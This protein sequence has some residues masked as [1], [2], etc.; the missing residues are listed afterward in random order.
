MRCR[1]AKEPAVTSPENPLPASVP[2]ELIGG[3]VPAGALRSRRAIASA[4]LRPGR[5]MVSR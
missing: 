2:D 1:R 5:P 3:R 4:L